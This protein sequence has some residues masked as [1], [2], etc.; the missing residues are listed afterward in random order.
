MPIMVL[1]LLYIFSLG[2]IQMNRFTPLMLL[3]LVVFS[4]GIS[5]LVWAE[6]DK[7][8]EDC[9][10]EQEKV[11]TAENRLEVDG[12]KF[13][14]RNAADYVNLERAVKDAET[15]LNRCKD[16]IKEAKTEK[17]SG[18]K[19]KLTEYN[20]IVEDFP[21]EA[22][23]AAK[24]CLG[25]DSK[26]D[27]KLTKT[28]LESLVGQTA[29]GEARCDIK[30]VKSTQKE[31]RKTL[32]TDAEKLDE[33]IRKSDEELLKKE[34]SNMEELERINEDRLKEKDDWEK[35]QTDAEAAQTK[36]LSAMRDKQLQLAD[37]IRTLQSQQIKARQDIN[38]IEIEIKAAMSTAKTSTGK[39]VNLRS[40]SAIH[41]HCVARAKAVNKEN[42]SAGNSKNATSGT[43][44]VKALKAEYE[45]C[46][47]EL[48]DQRETVTQ[49]YMNS[50]EHR[51]KNAQDITT[52]LDETQKMYSQSVEDYNK[53]LEKLKEGLTKAQQK[54]FERDSILANKYNQAMQRGAQ[55]KQRITSNKMLDQQKLTGKYKSQG[56]ISNQEAQQV[57]SKKR[58]LQAIYDDAKR[59]G[60]DNFDFPSPDAEA[61]SIE[62]GSDEDSGDSLGQ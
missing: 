41:L 37:S 50:A 52:K 26:D 4:L 46:I 54:Y 28:V 10:K 29:R 5:N 13:K 55:E 42:Y 34:K 2:G 40:E 60:C 15:K 14:D 56:R 49:S 21:Y 43:G 62:E 18:C 11:T 36:A 20:K 38:S 1:R 45:S 9:S 58:R 59:R 19:D 16:R 6:D 48:R 39:V 12:K 51:I 61:K 30:G 25:G 47:T 23:V 53:L 44:R 33:K 57:L 8:V 7:K 24:E 27:L 22:Q 35:S 32:D 17:N 3:T 31:E